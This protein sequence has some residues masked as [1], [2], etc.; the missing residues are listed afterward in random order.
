MGAYVVG[1]GVGSPRRLATAGQTVHDVRLLLKHG[2]G[3]VKADDGPSRGHNGIGSS[4]A[5][6]ALDG[7]NK[8]ATAVVMGA[9]VCD[10]TAALSA[11]VHAPHMADDELTVTSAAHVSLKEITEEG[12][13]IPVKAD[14]TWNELRR[15]SRNPR[16]TVVMDAW[17]NGPAVRLQDSAWIREPAEDGYWSMGKSLAESQKNR[18]EG[19]I[20]FLGTDEYTAANLRLR[21]NEPVSW[22][23]YAEPQVISPEFADRVRN[24][25][26]RVPEDQ[27]R[28]IGSRMIQE[29][30]GMNPS[31][32]AHR[33][34]VESVLVAANTL[35]SLPRPRVVPRDTELQED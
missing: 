30:Y 11:I 17:A 31:S 20:P 14:H 5:K 3:N 29:A 26:S 27:K 25:L 16:S 34:A 2:R 8:V 15:G 22:E 6:L 33:Y 24:A 9:A 12:D 18:V 23:K 4:V 10:Q 21:Q 35:D 32:Y 19:L 7:P 13:E 28:E 1:D